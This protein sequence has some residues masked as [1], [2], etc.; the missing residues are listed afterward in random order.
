[1]RI[2]LVSDTHLSGAA[3]KL[4]DELVRGLQGV[5]LILHAGDWT[6]ERAV[7]LLERIA[8]V[9]GVAGNNDGPEL[10]RRFGRK[11]LLEL[12][13]CRI[14][15][16]HGDIGWGRW[17]EQKALSSFEE[18][19]PDLILFGH[20]HTP[21]RKQH[22]PSLLFNPGS[23]LQKRRQPRYSFGLLDIEGGRLRAEHVYYDDRS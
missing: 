23:P 16:V 14:G 19:R 17:T 9:D 6:H 7:S 13:G 20:S 3:A 8:P 22:G 11:R 10:A 12:G 2:G 4:P 18:E 5:E 21:Y 15:I 1:M